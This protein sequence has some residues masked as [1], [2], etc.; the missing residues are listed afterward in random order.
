V[1]GCAKAKVMP[2]QA[3]PEG[4][5]KPDH[6]QVYDFA[7]TPHEV[8]LDRG[9]SPELVR[10]SRGTTQTDEEIRIGHAVATAMAK[11]LVQALRNQGITAYR[12][13]EAPPP[14]ATTALITGQFRRIDQGNRT[15]RTL[16]GFG[17]GGSQVQTHIQ[18]YQGMGTSARLVAEGD[19]TTT[20][21]LKPG[22]GVMLPVGAAAG[23]VGT[24]A[25]VSGATT[26]SSEAFFATV[27]ADAKRTAQEVAKRVTDYYKRHGWL[28]P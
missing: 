8:A 21:G 5:A 23:S 19:T 15:L 27:D 11:H 2:S 12:A 20:S 13:V 28:A 26:V 18:V 7:V 25:A 10:E 6:I 1:G 24:T 16:V 14:S 4:L 17:L 22:M 3:A 9:L